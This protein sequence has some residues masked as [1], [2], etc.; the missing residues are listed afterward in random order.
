MPFPGFPFKRVRTDTL[1]RVWK[2]ALRHAIGANLFQTAG[3]LAYTTIL[4]IIP[5]LAVSLSIFQAFKGLDRVYEAIEPMIVENL[6]ENAGQQAMESIRNF[7][8][9]IHAGTLGIGGLIG[10]I[11]TSMSLLNS[12]ERALNRIWDTPLRRTWFERISS[13]WLFITIGPVSLA[14]VLG[15]TGASTASPKVLPS[16][17]WG[18]LILSSALLVVYKWVPNRHVRWSPALIPAALMALVFVVARGVYGIYVREIVAYN[19]IYG[20]LAAVPILILWIWIVW[21]IVL[22]GA[23]VSASLQAELERETKR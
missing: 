19:K 4:S 21:V 9:N 13:Y 15:F 18:Y 3:S 11:L 20:S 23:A 2:T 14:G 17:V 5:F 22:I 7:I 1:L 12:A 10:L 8:S 16:G 6:A